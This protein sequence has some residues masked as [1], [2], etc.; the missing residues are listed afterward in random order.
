MFTKK[1]QKFIKRCIKFEGIADKVGGVTR[2]YVGMIF[3]GERDMKSPKAQQIF[4]EFQNILEELY[5]KEG[6]PIFAL[7][8]KIEN[9]LNAVVRFSSYQMA[10]DFLSKKKDAENYYI[11]KQK[12]NGKHWTSVV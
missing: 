1:E 9:D 11:E 6:I 10:L 4:L 12:Y 8:T 2:E 3:R 7:I 5:A